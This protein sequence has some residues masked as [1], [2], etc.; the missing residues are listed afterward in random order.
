MSSVPRQV[1]L[2]SS[3][4]RRFTLK[5][6][7]LASAAL[8][9]LAQGASAYQITTSETLPS[10]ASF[11][12]PILSSGLVVM[13]TADVTVGGTT[14]AKS[15]F[16]GVPGY[17]NAPYNFIPGGFSAT[18]TQAKNPSFVTGGDTFS[19]ILGSP[20]A[21]NT[22]SFSNGI[23]IAGGFGT[24]GAGYEV[25]T[26][27]GLG[28]YNAVTFASSQNSLEFATYDVSSVPLPT[29]L[30]MFALGLLGLGGMAFARQRRGRRVAVLV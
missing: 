28:S 19:F 9:A 18:F 16:D 21:F 26:V 27:S 17:E 14:V 2:L 20:D 7:L 3:R 12:T 8:L 4:F 1:G 30:P 13:A 25:V 24:S 10:L 23:S 11:V 15:P 5:Q 29:S 6:L 22:L